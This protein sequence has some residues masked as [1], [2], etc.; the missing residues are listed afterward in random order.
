MT[1]ASWNV[2]SIKARIGHV[3][4]WLRSAAPDVLCLQELKTIA[5]SFP[6]LE[7]EAAGYRAALVGQKAYNGVAILVREGLDFTV[8]AHALPGDPADEQARYVEAEVGPVRI[9]SIYLPNGNPAPGPKFDYKLAWMARLAA[10]ARRLLATEAP[11]VLAGDYN[12]CPEDRDAYDPKGLAEDA[13]LRPESRAAFRGILHQ[14]YTDAFRALH[15]RRVAYTYWDYFQNAWAQDRGLRI[16]HL[17]LSPRA[18][19][20]LAACD[21][22]RAP[23]DKP[24]ASDHTPIWCRLDL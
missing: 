10:H 9:A 13:L 24:Q 6:R 19:E 11:I 3:A 20:T 8:T 12:V 4:A 16:D 5:D 18:A 2:N 23:R 15:P 1:V 14:G 7:V 17:L 21:I 22:D